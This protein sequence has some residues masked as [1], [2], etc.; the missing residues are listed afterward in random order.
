MRLRTLACI[1]VTGLLLAVWPA[2]ARPLAQVRLSSLQAVLA[3]VG[4]VTTAAGRPLSGEQLLAGLLGP[5]GLRDVS[6]LD[7][8]R[9]LAA[10][11][12]LEGMLLQQRGVVVALPV[13]AAQPLFDALAGNASS[14]SRDGDLEVFSQADGAAVYA[15]ERDGYVVAGQS[16][17][18]VVGFDL[19][20]LRT[21]LDGP[22]GSAV[23]ELD[24]E[25]LAP[26]LQASLLGAREQLRQQVLSVRTGPAAAQPPADA[27]ALAELLDLYLDAVQAVLLDLSR[28]QVGLEVRGE[29]L[30][31]HARA[32]PRAGTATAA[33]VA[34]QE[35]GLP[36]LARVVPPAAVNLAGQVRLTPVAQSALAER[37]GRHLEL[38]ERWLE[39]PPQPAPAAAQ[40][41]PGEA[42]AHLAE[43]QTLLIEGLECFS[44]EVALGVEF[45]ALAGLNLF[46]VVGTSDSPR[47]RDLASRTL[48]LAGRFPAAGGGAQVTSHGMEAVGGISAER[49]TVDVAGAG[50]PLGVEEQRVLQVLYGGTSVGGFTAGTGSAT[51]YTLGTRARTRLEQMVASAGDAKQIGLTAASFA[52]LPP[53]P[54]LFASASLPKLLDW[55]RDLL[56]AEASGRA[57]LGKL[58][59][60]FDGAG[61]VA[62]RSVAGLRFDPNGATLHLGVPLRLLAAA[63][64]APP[65]ADE[66]Q[67]P[68]KK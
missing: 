64:P 4:T 7:P 68:G 51:Y 16:R 27:A 26:L 41:A 44:G 46:E 32:V 37:L 30:M 42:A 23:A 10:V 5:L 35:G 3:D 50:A 13:T 19:G 18:L 60:S 20:L 53:G 36:P 21:P 43:W 38:A 52:P 40:P 29:H 25:P 45:S 28:I 67:T 65:A 8:T 54:G 9:P 2:A 11:L 56:P 34:Y 66:A 57:D 59:R 55:A 17:P 12:P 63:R 1:A 6:A 22:P 31:W 48:A 58:A 47:C 24:L 49:F 15:W 62:E 61:T 33:F 14:W 39:S